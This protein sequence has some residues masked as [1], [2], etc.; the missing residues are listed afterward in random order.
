MQYISKTIVGIAYTEDTRLDCRIPLTA[1]NLQVL[2]YSARALVQVLGT[3]FNF[4]SKRLF[5]DP[6][7]L[8]TFVN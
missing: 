4:L 6:R 5:T 1:L 2:T 7:T 3:S 8:Q